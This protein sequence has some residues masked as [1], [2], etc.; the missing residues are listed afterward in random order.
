MSNCF[1]TPWAVGHQTPLSMGFP[2]QEYWS[3]LSFPSPEDLPDS[4]IEP[5]SPALAGRFFITKPP[6]KLYLFKNHHNNSVRLSPPL[7]RLFKVTNWSKV[8]QLS[9]TENHDQNMAHSSQS[10]NFSIILTMTP[11]RRGHTRQSRLA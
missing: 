1:V 10:Q 4:G 2:R 7:H 11:L 9:S 6:E 3:G 5:E 8:T